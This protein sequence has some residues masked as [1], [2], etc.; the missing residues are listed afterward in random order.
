MVIGF[1]PGWSEN[2]LFAYVFL[3][4]DEPLAF[5][6]MFYLRHPILKT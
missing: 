3:P 2:F 5:P 6:C 1:D 4:L